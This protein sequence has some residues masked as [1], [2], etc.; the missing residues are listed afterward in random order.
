[1]INTARVCRRFLESQSAGQ[2][3]SLEGIKIPADLRFESNKNGEVK[4]IASVGHFHTAIMLH[5]LLNSVGGNI[6]RACAYCKKPFRVGPGS[7]PRKRMDAKFCSEQ[8]Q[9]DNVSHNRS[10]GSDNDR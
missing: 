2:P 10:K 7:K 5:M 1:M 3:V 6:V 9:I 8:C 4:M